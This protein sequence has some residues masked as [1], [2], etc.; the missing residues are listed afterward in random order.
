MKQNQSLDCICFSK[1]PPRNTN[2]L[3]LKCNENNEFSLSV[4]DQGEWH[5]LCS[6]NVLKSSLRMLK[7]LYN[8]GVVDIREEIELKLNE[9]LQNLIIDTDHINYSILDKSLTEVL[10]EFYQ[11]TQ[12]LHP[13]AFSGFYTDLSKRE[14]VYEEGDLDPLGIAE[15]Y[16]IWQTQII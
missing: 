15:I 2:V 14:R 7:M 11:T 4:Y 3:W 6:E 10:E 12:N 9:K 16:S 5:E 1:N 8:K 13:V